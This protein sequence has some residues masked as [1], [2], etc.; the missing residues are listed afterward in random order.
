MTGEASDGGIFSQSP[1]LMARG[2]LGART[3]PPQAGFT[4]YECYTNRFTNDI[5]IV[6]GE[7]DIQTAESLYESTGSHSAF[8]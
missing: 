3:P 1:R 4:M 5:Q 6:L 2:T 8:V 7:G